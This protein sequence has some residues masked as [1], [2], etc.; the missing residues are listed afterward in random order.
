VTA[1]VSPGESQFARKCSLC[2][3]LRPDGR[4]RAGPTLY[5]VFGRKAGTLPGYPYSDALLNADIVW[6]EETIGK[7]FGLGPD[8]Y[9]PGTKMPLQ[10]ISDPEKR[11]ALIAYLK[12]AT[13]PEKGSDSGNKSS[14]DAG[15]TGSG[16]K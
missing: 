2:H 14:K 13:S 9:T 5:K 7:L 15:N 1:A 11:K 8:H 16:E 6:S 4:N 3:T 12:V 10:K